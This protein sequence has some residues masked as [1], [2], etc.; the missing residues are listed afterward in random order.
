MQEVT[1]KHGHKGYCGACQYEAAKLYSDCC[2]HGI[3]VGYYCGNC[4]AAVK[5]KPIKWN[6]TIPVVD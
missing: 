2:D 6:E 1:C 5:S 3:P 4:G